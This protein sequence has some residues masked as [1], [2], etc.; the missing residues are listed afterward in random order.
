MPTKEYWKI[1][2]PEGQQEAEKQEIHTIN[3]IEELSKFRFE[4]RR[5]K[6][7]YTGLEVLKITAYYDGMDYG[8]IVSKAAK[9]D[10]DIPALSDIGINL[11]RVECSD[12]CDVIKKNYYNLIPQMGESIENNIPDKLLD[13]VLSYFK[14][15]IDEKDIVVENGFYNIPVEDFK[16]AY[17]ESTFRFYNITEVKEALKLRHYIRCNPK[18]NDFAIKK[19]DKVQK[20]IS[21]DVEAIDSANDIEE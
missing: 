14:A 3:G 17:T 16:K 12:L 7:V 9:L 8:T 20:Y 6:D 4:I 1:E 11:T 2:K 19:N 13:K 10:T 5:L 18:R 21:F 15:Y